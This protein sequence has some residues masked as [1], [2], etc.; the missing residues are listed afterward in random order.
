MARPATDLFSRAKGQRAEGG[1]KQQ[2]DLLRQQPCCV[3]LPESPAT[4]TRVKP[5]LWS[6]QRGD[7]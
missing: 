7:L 5:I 3:L 4:R 6:S 2:G 1:H